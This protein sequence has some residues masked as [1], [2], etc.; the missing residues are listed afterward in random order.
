[1]LEQTVTELELLIID[2]GST[3]GTG[4]V[5]NRLADGDHR[6]RVVRMEQNVG[7]AHSLNLGLEEAQTP[8]VV[9]LD[10]DDWSEP[11]RLER[12]LAVLDSAPDIAVVGSRMRE[13]DEQGREL[14]P[15]TRFAPGEV[16]SVLMHF[17][18]IPNTSAMLRR[19]LAL[20]AGGYDPRYRWAAEYDLWLRLAERYRVIALDEVLAT[21]EMSS[22]NVAATREREQLAETI[23]I[24]LRA[25]A[26]RRSLRG[27][28]GLI[29]PSLSY[30][31][32][33][34]LKRWRRRRLGQ[35]P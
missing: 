7:I 14:S 3:D 22:R 25:M 9:I 32:P 12:Q 26:R 34:G 27:A 1:M 28:G 15:R 35:A 20:A 4:E 24:R 17:N 29:A 16:R 23:A 2:D 19:D 8:F 18:P 21:R 10:A 6:V 11:Q 5:A 13:V 33:L 30:L 31:T